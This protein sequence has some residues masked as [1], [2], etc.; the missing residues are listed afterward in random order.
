MA[1][2]VDGWRVRYL[3]EERHMSKASLARRAGVSPRT[4][5]RMESTGGDSHFQRRGVFSVADALGVDARA[6]SGPEGRLVVV[7][8]ASGAPRSI[9][10]SVGQ[11]VG[12]LDA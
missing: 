6:L 9:T 3:R 12:R 11:E 8:F 2:A 4:I 1:L 7:D 10:R 5:E